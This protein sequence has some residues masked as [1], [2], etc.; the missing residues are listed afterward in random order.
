MPNHDPSYIDEDSMSQSLVT[1]LRQQQVDVVTAKD[2]DQLACSDNEQLAWATQE[3]R[4]LYSS[5]IADFC[6][7][8][9]QWLQAGKHHAGLILVKQQQYSVGELLK[10]ILLIQ[11]LYSPED[12][13][14]QFIFL[15]NF[16]D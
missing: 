8:H 13:Q 5:N 14:D 4:V 9:S 15:S 10:G 16:M 7:L 1:A 12:V 11:E 6:R 3:G 2:V